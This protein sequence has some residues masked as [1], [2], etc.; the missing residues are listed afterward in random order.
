MMHLV[1]DFIPFFSDVPSTTNVVCHDVEAVDTTPCKQHPY[2]LNPLQ[3]ETIQKEIDYM[4]ENGIIK[5]NNSDWSSLCLL[6]PKLDWSFH[7][8]TGQCNYED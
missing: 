2:Q 3:L 5:H 6:V 8:C 4:L 1:S 7:L